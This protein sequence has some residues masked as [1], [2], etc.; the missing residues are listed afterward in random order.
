MSEPRIIIQKGKRLL[1]TGCCPH[2]HGTVTKEGKLRM[3]SPHEKRN[4]HAIEFTP[5][6]LRELANEIERCDFTASGA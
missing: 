2:A 6:K 4:P 3:L 1:V 5:A